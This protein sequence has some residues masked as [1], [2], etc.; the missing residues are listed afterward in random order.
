MNI[1]NKLLSF[2]LIS[3][4]ITSCATIINGT[5]QKV[6]I[7]SNPS[8]AWIWVDRN[9]VGN[10]PLV[11]ELSRKDNHVVRIELPGYMPYEVQFTKEV[12]GWVFGNIVFGGFIGL[13]VDA[14]S[15]G[16]YR[17]TPEQVNAEL[18]SHYGIDSNNNES[19]ISVVL[20]PQTG[21]EKIGNLVPN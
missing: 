11:I 15:G 21:W 4:T 3:T 9:Y 2:L 19:F 7:S 17:L 18:R 14:V 12:S 6:G 8:D 5:C 10:T 1:I 20:E 13:A 16:I